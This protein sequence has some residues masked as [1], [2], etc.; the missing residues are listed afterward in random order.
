MEINILK[1]RIETLSLINNL[2]VTYFFH[3]ISNKTYHK[4]DV[5][6]CTDIKNEMICN[7]INDIE[8][9]HA[10]TGF[11]KLWLLFRH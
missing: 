5:S 10:Q 9:F 4:N 6:I 8:F 1:F 2:V 11:S 7:Q 3:R